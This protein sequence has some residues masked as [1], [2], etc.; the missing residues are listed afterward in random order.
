MADV[1]SDSYER[2]F[3]LGLV[4]SEREIILSI[5]D[6]LKRI[7]NKT[8]G[9][10]QQCEKPISKN[11]LEAIPYAEYCIKCKEKLEKENSL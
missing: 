10:C 9:L 4:S 3:N 1:A 6:A 11:R 5:D 7:S 2:D 8:Y